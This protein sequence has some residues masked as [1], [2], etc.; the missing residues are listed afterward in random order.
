MTF[1]PSD[2]YEKFEA[3]ASTMAELDKVLEKLYQGAITNADDSVWVF[4]GVGNAD[5]GFSSSLYRRAWWTKAAKE[6]KDYRSVEPPTEAELAKYEKQVLIDVHRAGLHEGERGRLSILRQLALLQ[7]HHAPTRL[8]DVSFNIWVA[9]WFASQESFDAG[10]V[11]PDATDGRLFIIDITRRLI[12]EDQAERPWE[13]AHDTPW[14]GS[15]APPNWCHV[16]RAWKPA[17][18]ERRIAAQHGAFLLGGV[19]VSSS[20]HNYPKSPDSGKSGT[21]LSNRELRT[22]TSI[23]LRFHKAL[24][25]TGYSFGSSKSPGSPAFTIRI[26][27]DLKPELRTRLRKLHGFTTTTIYPDVPGFGRFGTPWMVERPAEVGA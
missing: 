20:E 1:D 16:A 25:K 6:G 9:L 17:K 7:H 15:N 11:A 21:W 19:P 5:H 2:L 14:S 8:I 10:L 12:N 4:R 22:C 18:I 13:D 23:P 24:P 26:A 3:T 27:Q